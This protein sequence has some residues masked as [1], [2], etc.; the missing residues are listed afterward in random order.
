MSNKS[1]SYLQASTDQSALAQIIA[2]FGIEKVESVAFRLGKKLVCSERCPPVDVEH[3]CRKLRQSA[4]IAKYGQRRGEEKE[5]D[6][7]FPHSAYDLLQRMMD[8]D[9]VTRITAA[10]AL[11]HPFLKDIGEMKVEKKETG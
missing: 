8:V 10:E 6:Q 11:Q 7:L 4:L 2:I 5:K 9:A 1:I 3:M